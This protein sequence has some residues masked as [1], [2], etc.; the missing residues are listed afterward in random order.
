MYVR[1]VHFPRETSVSNFKATETYAALGTPVPFAPPPPP[2]LTILRTCTWPS[3]SGR[4]S[5]MKAS[6]SSSKV[7]TS[8]IRSVTRSSRAS[9]RW[10][11][12]LQVAGSIVVKMLRATRFLLVGQAITCLSASL[13][14]AVLRTLAPFERDALTAVSGPGE[15]VADTF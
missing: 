5:T 6:M 12:V 9:T 1:N 11:M 14:L 4:S 3:Y 10:S 13:T 7:R 8:S 15:L 2:E